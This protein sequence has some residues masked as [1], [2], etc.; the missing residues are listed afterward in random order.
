LPQ[1]I[2]E[3][4]VKIHAGPKLVGHVSRDATAIEAPSRDPRRLDTEPETERNAGFA[5]NEAG[6]GFGRMQD[7][8]AGFQPYRENSPY[9]MNRGG[10]GTV[11]T[12]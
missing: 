1:Q 8:Q 6:N 12:I 7:D 4:I 5:S 3:R 11:G 10:G 2:H 9:G